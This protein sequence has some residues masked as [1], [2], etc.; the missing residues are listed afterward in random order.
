[1]E[2]EDKD[3]SRVKGGLARAEIL[4]PEERHAIAKKAAIARWGE[5]PLK[6]F[7]K[8][9]FK[10]DF[11][12]DIDCYVLDDDQKTAVISKRGMG[13]AIGFSKRGDR[14]SIFVN[15]KNMENYVGR[16]IRDKIENP[17]IFQRTG[18]AARNPISDQ[19]HGYDA[20]ILIDICKAVLAAKNDGKLSGIK[21]NKMAEQAQIILTA[22]AKAGIKGLIYALAGYSPTTE[23][24]IAAFK[25]FVREEAREYEKEFPDQL[26][27]QW[28]R[29][30]QLPKPE[31][32][33]PWKFKH[34]T[35]KQV[36]TPLA[37]S[38]GKILELAQLKRAKKEEKHK[39]IH[40]FLS[41]IGVKA[42][43]QH[44]GQLLGISQISED[45]L[46]Y[47]RHFEKVF[48]DQIGLDFKAF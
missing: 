48:G 9:S 1:M 46:E 38:S 31:R 18:S 35:L 22:S 10:E 21:Y 2:N 41:E 20:T 26:Y 13:Q 3:M 44:L 39:R 34:L 25:L 11:G 6:V 12:I 47:E 4:S 32:N 8:G 5:K 19:T 43:R 28:Y 27:E 36:Y 42:L 24:V 37:K 17:I 23:E 15:S 7:R 45:H 30:Y 40:Q 14:L 33:K 16:E 29:L